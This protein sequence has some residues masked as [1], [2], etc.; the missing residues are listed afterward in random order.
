MNNRY[1]YNV[2]FL[3]ERERRAEQSEWIERRIDFLCHASGFRGLGA[4]IAVVVAVPGMSDYGTGETSITAQFEFPSLEEAE[5]WGDSHF[6]ALAGAYS[7]AFGS[8]AYA[9]PSIIEQ[10]DIDHG[11]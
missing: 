10:R 1:C 2:T 9:M 11:E 4:K 3:V 5:R 6:P 8:H 7:R